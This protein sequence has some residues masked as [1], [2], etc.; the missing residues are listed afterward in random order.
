MGEIVTPKDALTEGAGAEGTGAKVED[1]VRHGGGRFCGETAA[2]EAAGIGHGHRYLMA[3]TFESF[4]LAYL[5]RVGRNPVSTEVASE[6]VAVGPDAGR[7]EVRVRIVALEPG[8]DG[9]RE[10]SFSAHF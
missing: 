1:E 4:C 10:F 3:K 5:R 7:T 8:G 6:A 2:S 9:C